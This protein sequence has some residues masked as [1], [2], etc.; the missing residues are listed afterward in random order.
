MTNTGRDGFSQDLDTAP[1]RRGVFRL[2]G[3]AAAVAVL[4]ATGQGEVATARRR[5]K[6]CE[7]GC[8]IPPRSAAKQYT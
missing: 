8:P 6:R 5:K 1:T 7:Y 3:R 2:L 4:L